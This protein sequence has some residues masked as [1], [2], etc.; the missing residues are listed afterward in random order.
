MKINYKET[1]M[2]FLKLLFIELL[3]F[4][5]QIEIFLNYPKIKPKVNIK[6]VNNFTI[7]TS[8]FETTEYKITLLTMKHDNKSDFETA[9]S[10][11]EISGNTMH[12]VKGEIYLLC[13]QYHDQIYDKSDFFNMSVSGEL[14]CDFQYDFYELFKELRDYK[15]QMKLPNIE[16][17]VSKKI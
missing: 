9:K 5:N 7:L 10:F 11:S 16:I 4:E 6:R 12:I 13:N 15:D 14:I 1:F 8:S 3:E 2:N 17:C